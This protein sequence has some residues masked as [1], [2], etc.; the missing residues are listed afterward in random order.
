[1]SVP[2]RIVDIAPV[3]AVLPEPVTTSGGATGAGA[4]LAVRRVRHARIPGT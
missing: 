4:D 2:S 1:M 3:E